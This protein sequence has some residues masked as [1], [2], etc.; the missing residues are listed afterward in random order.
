MRLT[1]Y[2]QQ[3]PRF[4][5]LGSSVGTAFQSCPKSGKEGSLFFSL[6]YFVN[7]FL[8]TGWSSKELDFGQSGSAQPS[9]D[10]RSAIG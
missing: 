4:F 7:A 9:T 2:S 3:M 5:P 8:D 1:V 6:C 10:P